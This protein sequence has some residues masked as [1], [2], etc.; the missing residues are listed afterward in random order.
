MAQY[1]ADSILPVKFFNKDTQ[2]TA[3]ILT[4]TL[5]LALPR[6]KAKSMARLL[7]KLGATCSQAESNGTT[8]LHRYIEDGNSDLIDVLLESD[9]AAL[10]SAVNHLV[11]TGS[12]WSARTIS[13]LH[14]AIMRGDAGLVRKLLSLGALPHIDFQTW[15]KAAKLNASFSERLGTLEVNQ[16]KHAQS[17]E[18]PLVTAIRHGN[19]DIAL[20]LLDNGADANTLTQETQNLFYNKYQRNYTKGK[21]VL[22]VV[23]EF[24]SELSKYNG[25]NSSNKKP[26]ERPGMETYLQQY[27]P[28][29]YQH[30]VIS[31]DI[32][33]NKRNFKKRL[34]SY[35]KE[36]KRIASL[37][38][39][40]EKL[41]AIQETISGFMKLE[42]AL[43]EKGAK[44]FDELHPDIKTKESSGYGYHHTSSESEEQKTEPYK[45]V[46]RFHNDKDL[47][48]ARRDGYFEL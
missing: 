32:A 19:S 40:P 44:P 36:K 33:H 39:A 26:E 29:S 41:Q 4:L 38:G 20:E 7:L 13:P 48:E 15:L 2:E 10:K 12:Y 42:A 46:F 45:Y 23:R 28:G 30:F 5:A 8:A 11:L 21:S 27:Q 25:E 37:A 17:L 35:E 31:E 16:H 22:D 43:I 34:E 3:A 47:T 18:Q 9:K 24:V 6:E 14:T 1:G